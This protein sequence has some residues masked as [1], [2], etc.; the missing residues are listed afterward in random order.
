METLVI[1]PQNVCSRKMT[2]EHENGVIV[3]A[4]VE[5]GC[6]GNLQ[7]I[8]RLIEGMKI[9]QVISRLQG[10]QCRNGTSCPDQLANGLKELVK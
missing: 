7:G 2:I 5:G 8:C 10:V 3:H 1:H 4:S 6:R 9:E